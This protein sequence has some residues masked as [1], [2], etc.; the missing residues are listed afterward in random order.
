MSCLIVE[1]FP[2]GEVAGAMFIAHWGVFALMFFS[3]HDEVKAKERALKELEIEKSC[4]SVKEDQN[5][6][7][8]EVLNGKIVVMTTREDGKSPY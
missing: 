5:E 8:M 7:L 2:L 4:L 3:Y 6:R 1:Q